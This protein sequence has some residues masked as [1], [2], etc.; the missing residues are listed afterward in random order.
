MRDSFK[1]VAAQSGNPYWDNM[2][3]RKRALYKRENDIRSDF[4]R[5][6]T[7]I[8]HCNAYRRLKHKTQVFFSPK[9]DHVCTRIEHVNYVESIS[10]TIASYLG[11]NTQLT[12]AIATAHDI[13][14]SPFGHKGEKV[15]NEIC[16]RD[17]GITFWHE[18]NG[19]HFVDDIELLE[20]DK[21]DLRNLNL[22]YAVRDGIIS[23][24]GEI[25]ENSLKPRKEYIDLKDYTYP[26]EYNPYTW[27]GCVVKISD[28]ISYIGRDLEDA[29]H[30]QLLDRYRIK[31]L[32]GILN[33]SDEKTLN[34]PNIIND[35]IIDLCQNSSVEKGLCFSEE[36]LNLLD[37]IKEFNYKNIYAHPRLAASNEYFSVIINRI[38][39][40]LKSCY[41]EGEIYRGLSRV[42]KF[43]PET[44]ATFKDWLY[45]Y[46]DITD[47]SDTNL[48]NNVVYKLSKGDE[49]EYYKSIIDFIAGMTDNY[50]IDVYNEILR[51]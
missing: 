25:D 15:L 38:Y 51:F 31:E 3:K 34:N 7:R 35:L 32:K 20:D 1:K 19:V 28:K 46:S 17:I 2:I 5:D 6:Y 43:Y 45:K 11:L 48:K 26:N 33:I 24:C 37:K 18:K 22:T 10:N 27:E 49:K 12:R 50:A 21:G 23:H 47:R 16:K 44:I 13:G 39:D 14:H 29:L 9:S 4:E 8:L 42:E 41:N 30:L 36:K 40:T